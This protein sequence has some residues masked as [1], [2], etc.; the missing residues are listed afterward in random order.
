MDV[1]K[2]INKIIYMREKKRIDTNVPE[3]ISKIQIKEQ[4]S[5]Q[6]SENRK[7]QMRREKSGKFYT[8]PDY[9]P[10]T[11]IWVKN[12]DNHVVK[13]E[14]FKQKIEANGLIRL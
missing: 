11:Q 8:V 7:A 2:R 14:L 12:G 5:K 13:C 4:C 1:R 3:I 6:Q 9:H 10:H